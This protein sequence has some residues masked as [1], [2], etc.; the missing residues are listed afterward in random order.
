MPQ[1]N[2]KF[3]AWSQK[4]PNWFC[5]IFFT[6]FVSVRVLV[7]FDALTGM[8]HKYGK[9]GALAKQ[10]K[11]EAAARKGSEIEGLKIQAM[12][13]QLKEFKARLQDFALKHKKAIQKDPEFRRDFQRMCDVVGVDALASQKGFWSQVFG[14]GDFY[15]KLGVSIV[16]ICLSTRARN[17]GIMPI[18]DLMVMLQDRSGYGKH[19]DL[20]SLSQDDVERAIKKLKIL[21]KG[22][23]IILVGKRKLVQSVPTELNQDH[24]EIMNS[25]SVNGCTSAEKLHMELGWTQT[26]GQ[27]GLDQMIQE[28]MA[29][30]DS[31]TESGTPEYY[32]PGVHTTQVSGS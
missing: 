32:L 26:R 19:K 30:V 27:K 9:R 12:G 20:S 29:W 8:A 11:L 14:V 22:F 25:V 28:G 10:K 17:G 3:G 31:K 6:H 7:D 18:E 21:G 5:F 13:E 1:R 15:Y 16:D 4:M 23:E 24:T 2:G